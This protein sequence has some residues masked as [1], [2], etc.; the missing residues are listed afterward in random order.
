MGAMTR[1][2]AE[3]LLSKPALWAF[4]AGLALGVALAGP[5]HDHEPEA[6]QTA[7]VAPEPTIEEIE[8]SLK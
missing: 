2:L 4:L 8:A 3:R 6:P 1:R 5:G 7:E